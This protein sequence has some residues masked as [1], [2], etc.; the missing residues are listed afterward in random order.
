MTIPPI[1]AAVSV[2]GPVLALPPSDRPTPI[3]WEPIAPVAPIELL[4]SEVP[5]VLG[6]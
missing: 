4:V 1:L 2:R 3:P 5:T 6:K